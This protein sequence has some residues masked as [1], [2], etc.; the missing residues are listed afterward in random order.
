M[1]EDRKNFIMKIFN[2]IFNKYLQVFSIVMEY[3]VVDYMFNLIHLILLKN[4]QDQNILKLIHMLNIQPVYQKIHS[5]HL[6]YHNQVSIL[7]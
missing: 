6:L 1:D 7:F 3:I 5:M 2:I 4:I